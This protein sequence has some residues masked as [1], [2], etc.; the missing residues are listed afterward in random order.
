VSVRSLVVI[1]IGLALGVGAAVLAIA[2]SEGSGEIAAARAPSVMRG[3]RH[4][5][6]RR[7][8][9]AEE[10]RRLVRYAG[11]LYACLTD[12]GVD[13]SAPRKDPRTITI[14]AAEAVGLER[15]VASATSC[16]APLGDPP[17][18]SSLQAVDARTIVLSV[19]KQCLLDPNTELPASERAP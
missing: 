8:L 1:A 6:N 9:T 4:E 15:L 12:R 5:A 18:P 11:A 2:T 10:T 7:V 16:A 3:T 19:P 14:E 13:V 17:T